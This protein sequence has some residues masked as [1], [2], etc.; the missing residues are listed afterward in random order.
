MPERKPWKPIGVYRTFPLPIQPLPPK[1]VPSKPFW[2]YKILN[3]TP[4][5]SQRPVDKPSEK[6]SSEMPSEPA[7]E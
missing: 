6:D 7:S 5:E 1:F 2:P 4:L 3:Q